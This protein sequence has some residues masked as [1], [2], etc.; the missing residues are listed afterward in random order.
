MYNKGEKRKGAETMNFYG[1]KR[2]NH[3]ERDHAIRWAIIN[4]IM[5]EDYG[6]PTCEVW[7]RNSWN[8]V[9]TKGL[10]IVTNEQRDCIVTAYF[11]SASRVTKLYSII[12]KTL[13]EDFA[14]DLQK[15]YWWSQREEDR[16]MVA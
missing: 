5:G 14:R 2:T 4:E 1:M 10:Y 13:S 9:T 15:R 11:P 8:Y 3:C 12:N 7:Y 6:E 16:R